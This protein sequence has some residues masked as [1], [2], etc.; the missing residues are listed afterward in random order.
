MPLARRWRRRQGEHLMI[1]LSVLYPAGE[2]TKFDMNYYCTSHMP[3][4]REKFGAACKGMTIEQGLAGGAPGTPPTYVAMGHFLFD[5]VADLQA[6]MAPHAATLMGDIPN[7][8]NVQP[9]I[10]ISE[11][12]L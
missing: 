7:Y 6:A 4:A 9:V 8:S 1:K 11:V 10:Q 3:M 12:K 5:S 2:S